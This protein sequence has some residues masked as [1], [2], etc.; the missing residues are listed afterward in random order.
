MTRSAS[1]FE[2]DHTTSHV[3]FSESADRLSDE[4]QLANWQE[5]LVDSCHAISQQ[6]T[7][8]QTD[9]HRSLTPSIPFRLIRGLPHSDEFQ[10][11]LV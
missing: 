2:D 3:E 4:E 7:D 1:V 9:L 5:Q 11:R 10:P 8:I 6:L